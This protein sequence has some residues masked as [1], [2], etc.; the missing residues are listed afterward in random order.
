[1][2]VTRKVESMACQISCRLKR[3]CR[4]AKAM[5][6]N[7]PRAPASVGVARPMNSV[8]R[9]RKISTMEGNMPHS[10]RLIRAAPLSVRASSGKGGTHCGRSTTTPSVN[11]RNMAVC[12]M[13]GPMAPLYM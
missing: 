5:P 1:M 13:E 10:T 8:P 9:T 4:A 12:N 7:A 3:P 11:N 6:P 2:V